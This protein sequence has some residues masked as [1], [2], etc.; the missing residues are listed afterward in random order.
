MSSGNNSEARFTINVKEGIVELEGKE[1]FV[2]KHL[3]KF[4]EIFKTAVKEAIASGMQQQN[5]ALKAQ[6]ALPQEVHEVPQVPDGQATTTTTAAVAAKPTA[7]SPARHA[8]RVAPTLPPIPVDLKA[9]ESKPGLREFYAE[10]K[11]Q[12]HYEKTAVFAYYITKFNKQQEVKFGEILSC[13][14]EVNEKKPSVID[15]VKNSVRYKGWL[16]QGSDKFSTRLTIS[17]ENYVKFDMPKK[18]ATA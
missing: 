11:P 1:S 12:N 14:E 2:D 8:P 17:G 4:E 18:D 16:E 10:K 9:N 15:I 3:E 13:Y 6:V 5:V 7:A